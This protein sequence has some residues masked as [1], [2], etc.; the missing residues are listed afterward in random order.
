[1]EH[2]KE[3]LKNALEELVIESKGPAKKVFKLCLTTLNKNN[4]VIKSMSD[5]NEIP[6]NKPVRAKLKEQIQLRK[7]RQKKSSSHTIPE[8]TRPPPATPLPTTQTPASPRTS[9][10]PTSSATLTPPS[11]E[12]RHSKEIYQTKKHNS[13][14]NKKKE[15]LDVT[16]EDEPEPMRKQKS[17]ENL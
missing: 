7:P 16:D 10:S 17:V 8:V 6:F 11:W 12:A 14:N 13:K 4:N 15:F 1:M 9:P 2:F 5:L 3:E